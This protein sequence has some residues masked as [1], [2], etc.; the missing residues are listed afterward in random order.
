MVSPIL[1]SHLETAVAFTSQSATTCVAFDSLVAAR[2][3][4]TELDEYC[5]ITTD[6]ILEACKF[7]G[8]RPPPRL[9]LTQNGLSVQYY[10]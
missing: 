1:N 8:A 2:V 3:A 4:G 6:N 7:A 9:H 10:T 5:D